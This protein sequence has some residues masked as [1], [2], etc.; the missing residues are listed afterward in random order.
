MYQSLPVPVQDALE[1][2]VTL[3]YVLEVGYIVVWGVCVAVT[4]Y[5]CVH[6]MFIFM[7]VCACRRRVN[8]C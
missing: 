3:L 6:N 1:T 2:V 5:S 4:F 7:C 8:L